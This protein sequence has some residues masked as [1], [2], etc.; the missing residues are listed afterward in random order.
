MAKHTALQKRFIVLR[1]AAFETPQDIAAAFAARFPDT[2]CSE[3]DVLASDPRVA[4]LPPPLEK[5]F[6]EERKR[7]LDADIQEVAPFAE[8]KARLIALSRQAERYESNNRPQDARAVY[9]QIAEEMGVIVKGG[10]AVA[11][12]PT[13]G[14]SAEVTEIRRTVVDPVE[15]VGNTDAA[16]VPAAAKAET[17]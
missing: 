10:K 5:A 3:Q 9:R 6:Y 7:I 4:L 14:D 17:V 11:T 16:G 13:G 12:I 15:S 8:Q 2:S 1:L